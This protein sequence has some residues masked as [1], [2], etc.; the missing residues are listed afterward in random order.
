[1][2]TREGPDIVLE[3]SGGVMT[4]RT[5]EAVYQVSVTTLGEGARTLPPAAQPALPGLERPARAAHRELPA[6]DPAPAPAA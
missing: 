6:G 1:M 5:Q 4:I 3:F 2:S